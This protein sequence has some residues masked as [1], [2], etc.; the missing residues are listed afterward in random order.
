MPIYKGSQEIK[1]IFKGTQKISSV[2][3]GTQ[4]V[5]PSGSGCYVWP[6]VGDD[7]N[8]TP[9]NC[10]PV[11]AS[12]ASQ[13]IWQP[14][15]NSVGVYEYASGLSY[16]N[17]DGNGGLNFYVDTSVTGTWKIRVSMEVYSTSP[18]WYYYYGMIENVNPY[19]FFGGGNNYITV[20]SNTWSTV[21]YEYTLT[22]SYVTS[23]VWRFS[24]VMWATSVNNSSNQRV[25]YISVAI[26]KI[27]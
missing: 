4:R 2:F 22:K 5:Y 14:K 26:D 10:V 18:T 23:Y 3:K 17:L 27:S 24:P 11:V 20:T 12:Y 6:H 21:Y 8:N 13:T 9:I 16:G 1:H 7:V 25:R 19:Y 15:Y